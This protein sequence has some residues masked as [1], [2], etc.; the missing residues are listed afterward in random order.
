MA[1]FQNVFI[2]GRAIYLPGVPLHQLYL[3]CFFNN[4]LKD[5]YIYK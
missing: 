1:E 2:N 5:D 4:S 3:L